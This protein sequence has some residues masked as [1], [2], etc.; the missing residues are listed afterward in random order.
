MATTVTRSNLFSEAWTN[1]KDLLNTRT[2]VADPTRANSEYRKFV[3][4]REPDVKSAEFQGYP[5]IIINPADV[6]VEE[7]GSLDMKSKQVSWFIEVEVVASDRGH[8]ESA[9]QGASHVDSISDDILETIL[10][11]TNRHTLKGNTMYMGTP[12]TTRMTVESF[13]NELV[14]RRSIMLSFRTYMTVSA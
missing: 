8:G 9:G 5:F 7:L 14:Y 10:N 3:Y 1:V 13:N 12:T 11:R 6:D 4:A 2:S